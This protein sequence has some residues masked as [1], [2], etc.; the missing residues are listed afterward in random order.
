MSASKNAFDHRRRVTSA[1]QIHSLSYFPQLVAK[2]YALFTTKSL[3]NEKLSLKNAQ[4]PTKEDSET[5]SDPSTRHLDKPY[6][7]ILPSDG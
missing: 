3:F 1:R 6:T 2:G 7:L 4:T 5:A